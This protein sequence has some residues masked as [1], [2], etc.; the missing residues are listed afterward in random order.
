M[1][2]R[3]YSTT[4]QNH[5]FSFPPETKASQ[6]TFDIQ[7]QKPPTSVPL[8]ILNLNSSLRSPHILLNPDCPL[9]NLHGISYSFM[10]TSP[11]VSPHFEI[12]WKVFRWTPTLLYSGLSQNSLLRQHKD[13]WL[14]LD[15]ELRKA[16]LGTAG[17]NLEACFCSC[18]CW[19]HCG[20]A[21][22]LNMALPSI[23]KKH[24]PASIRNTVQHL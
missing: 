15:G 4:F 16:L 11:S 17:S 5:F 12:C 22:N 6:Q 13:S 8:E 14:F 19:H 3:K 18:Q 7:P 23:Y 10:S 1:L 20:F 9:R 2:V 21:Q 24:C